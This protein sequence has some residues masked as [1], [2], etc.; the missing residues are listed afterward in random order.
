MRLSL[1]PD[2]S[3]KLCIPCLLKG[4]VYDT[5]DILVVFLFQEIRE[6]L[7]SRA[8]AVMAVYCKRSVQFT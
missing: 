4:C 7:D 3:R 5:G 1:H 6:C 2:K 8:D